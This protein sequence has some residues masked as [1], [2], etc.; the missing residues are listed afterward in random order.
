MPGPETVPPELAP[1][2]DAALWN[3]PDMAV[4]AL[5][6]TIVVCAVGLLTDMI[7]RLQMQPP[8]RP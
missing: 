5:L 3:R 1:I 2:Q 6:S 4:M 8:S 7:A